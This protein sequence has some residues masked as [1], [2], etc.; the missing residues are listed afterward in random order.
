MIRKTRFFVAM[1]VVWPLLLSPLYA[2]ELED[3][4][5]ESE[6]EEEKLRQIPGANLPGV[7]TQPIPGKIRLPKGED[8]DVLRIS[9]DR[10]IDPESYTVGPGDVLQLYIWGEFDQPIP[11]TINPEGYALVPTIGA[12][13]VSNRTLAEV[14][15]RIIAA[16]QNEKYPGVEISLTLES[17]RIFTVYLTGAVLTEGAFNVHPITRLSD[18]I[19]RSGGFVDDLRGTVEETVSSKKVTRAQFSQAQP[20]AR[21]SIRVKSL[22]G[23]SAE[24][25]LAMFLATG[26]LSLNPY[27]KMGDVV[28]VPYRT[29]EVFVY[30]S[31]N[32]EGAQEFKSGD[33]VGDLLTLAGDVS[34]SAPLEIAVIWRFRDGRTS[35]PISLID[36]SGQRS[37]K[38]V[39]DIADVPLQSKDMLFVRTRA[40]WQLTPT[41]HIH[42]EVKYRGRYRIVRGQTRIRDIVDLAGG[43]NEGASL[44]KA[45][46]IRA[47]LRNVRDP[48]FERVK[49]VQ[50]TGGL[51]DLDPEER[52]YLKSK[53]REERGRVTVDF[54]KLLKGDES[55]DILLEGGDVIFIPEKRHTVSLSGQ[56]KKPGLIY[57]KEGR[58]VSFYLD[59]AGGYGF[60]ADKRGARLIRA[61]TGQREKLNKNLIVDAGD[62]IWVPQQ[63]Y[64]NLWKSFQGLMRT[65]AET[66]TLV[67]LVRAL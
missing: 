3:L 50:Q 10:P 21:R 15:E 53:A 6:R 39:A 17:M 64:V 22:D 18:L 12:F 36:T 5:N 40:D 33:T 52:A 59:Q 7:A 51:G 43:I 31:V 38:T 42:G 28:H 54:E 19:D 4:V 56:L 48:E 55:Q 60:K 1:T 27:L 25:D 47:R 46:V 8:I 26:D 63:E 14:K 11:L 29:H 67:I 37:D 57:F 13:D 9:Q 24:V 45:R 49:S 62:E 41:V 32:E 65:V 34:G 66:L 23:S 30:G 35:S 16:A 44:S 20:T 2:Q 58:N 61:R